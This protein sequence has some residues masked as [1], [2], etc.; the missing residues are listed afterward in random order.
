MSRSIL[1]PALQL[2]DPIHAELEETGLPVSIAKA[3]S[4]VYIRS[5]DS[6]RITSTVTEK[7]QAM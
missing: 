7:Y 5:C 1:P 6:Y 3:I 4:D 2:P